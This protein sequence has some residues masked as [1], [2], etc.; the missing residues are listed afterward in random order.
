ML[1]LTGAEID[2]YIPSFPA[3]QGVFNVSVSMVEMTIS[4]NIT[5]HCL[6]ALLAG[7]LGDKYGRKS[8]ILI[9]LSMFIIGSLCCIF[10]TNFT[11]LL[12]GRVLQ[13]IGMSGPAVLSYVVISDMYSIKDQ[14]NL[15][16]FLNG[17]KTIAM[18][19]APVIGS[20]V[21]LFFSWQ[22]NFIILLL[23]GI[24]CFI[25]TIIA[26]PDS[27]PHP[28]SSISL[29]EYI[30]LI[31]S[32]KVMLY[33]AAICFL[34][35]SYW[36]FIAI[37]PIFYMDSLG[38]KLEHFGLYQ[39]SLATTFGIISLSSPYLF[40]KFGEKICFYTSIIIILTFIVIMTILLLTKNRDPIIITSTMLLLVAGTIIPINILYPSMIESVSGAKSKLAALI[41]SGKFML[42]AITIQILSFLYDETLF[43]IGII[44][45]IS[46]IVAIV[47]AFRLLHLDNFLEH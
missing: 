5:A 35:Q 26:I 39:G 45:S 13:G 8:I 30:P 25:M 42:T 7:N 23:M 3:L 12:F 31:K 32:K 11:F 6:S 27:T 36:V 47:S 15:I 28:E 4:I 33:T 40:R 22:G 1:I 19:F 18:G 20:Y 16:G 17:S 43:H 29:K 38:V 37:A 2:L 41:G 46:V 21:N 9:G 34:I 44:V 10:A 24:L 14:K